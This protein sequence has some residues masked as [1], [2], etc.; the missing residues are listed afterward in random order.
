MYVLS[1]QE[2][3]MYKRVTNTTVPYMN[4]SICNSI[5]VIYP[6]LNL[7]NKFAL[8]VEKIESMKVKYQE[9]LAEFE[10]LYGSVSQRAFKGILP[11]P[12]GN[13]SRIISRL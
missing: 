7:Q 9:S 8:I 2:K 12:A 3:Y 10:A 11:V 5:P 6:P 13:R 1:F 4:E